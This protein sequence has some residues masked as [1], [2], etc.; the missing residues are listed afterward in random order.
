MPK[1]KK[2][3]DAFTD[4]TWDDLQAWAGGRIVSRGKSYQRQGRVFDLA[5]T[6]E[7]SLVAWVK[8]SARYTTKVDVDSDGRPKSISSCPYEFDCKHGFAVVLEYLAR[9]EKNRDPFPIIKRK[10]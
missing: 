6:V 10:H 7:G 2:Q 8:G 1:K 4:L 3:L 5:A 9:V